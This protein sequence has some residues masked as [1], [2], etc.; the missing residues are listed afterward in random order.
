MQ[1]VDKNCWTSTSFNF[2]L[3][4]TYKFFSD[5]KPHASNGL[6]YYILPW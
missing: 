4:R 3:S 2:H 5:V 1:D 6:G